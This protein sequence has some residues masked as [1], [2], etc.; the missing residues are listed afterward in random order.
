MD[1]QPLRQKATEIRIELLKMI[2][3]AKAGH[4]GGSLSNTDILTALYYRIMNH[5]PQNP[6]DPNR[7]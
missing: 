4:T 6:K 7:V 2:T 5:N 1:I 3:E